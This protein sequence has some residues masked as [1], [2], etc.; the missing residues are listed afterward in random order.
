[1]YNPLRALADRRRAI[2]AAEQ[3][4]TYLLAARKSAGTSMGG[5]DLPNDTEGGV[6]ILHHLLRLHPNVRVVRT[7]KNLSL[8][9][10]QDVNASVTDEVRQTMTKKGMLFGPGGE[11]LL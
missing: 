4:Y 6:A 1:M 8:V 7:A 2:A 11:D 5:V 9:L 10:D 3:L